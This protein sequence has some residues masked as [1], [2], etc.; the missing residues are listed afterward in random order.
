[1]IAGLE[2]TISRGVPRSPMPGFGGVLSEQMIAG[3]ARYVLSP[4]SAD[5]IAVTLGRVDVGTRP[6]TT[7]ELIARGKKLYTAAGC[8]SIPSA[9][10]PY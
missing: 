8:V 1:M 6:P 7:P 5:L 3:L 10:G 4:G 9:P 2:R